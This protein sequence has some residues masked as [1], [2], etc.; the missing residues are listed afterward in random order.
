MAQPR[1]EKKGLRVLFT[2]PGGDLL[3]D[4]DRETPATETK[5]KITTLLAWKENS[6]KVGGRDLRALPWCLSLPPL[7][8]WPFPGHLPLGSLLSLPASWFQIVLVPGGR[9]T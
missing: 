3:T 1:R 8:H 6:I 7:P 4:R 5:D 2:D 9:A